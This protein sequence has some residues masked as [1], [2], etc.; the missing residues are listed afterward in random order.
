M[1]LALL[2]GVRPLLRARS[3]LLYSLVMTP[4]ILLLLDFGRVV[5][6]GLL[7]ERPLATLIGSGLVLLITLIVSRMSAEQPHYVVGSTAL[8]PTSDASATTPLP[9]CAK[10][11]AHHA[12]VGIEQEI[13]GRIAGAESKEGCQTR[14][15]HYDR[16]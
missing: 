15:R 2:G 14:L 1:L 9:D 6:T 16:W 13:P 11:Q 12:A 3:Y 4:L 8:G 10:S 5:D 7:W